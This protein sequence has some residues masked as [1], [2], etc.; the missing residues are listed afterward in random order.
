MY[1]LGIDP[2]YSGAIA[3]LNAD[4]TINDVCRF[5]ETPHDVHEWLCGR[6]DPAFAFIERVNAMPHQGVSSTFKFGKSYGFALGLLTA[7]HIAYEEITPAKWQKAM[8]C[9]TGGDKNV[10]KAA[11]QRLFPKHKMTHAEADALLIAELCRRMEK[12]A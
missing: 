12:G 6:D 2:G 11:A 1:Y 8:N 3:C 9:R 10:S 5:S 4:G 7:H